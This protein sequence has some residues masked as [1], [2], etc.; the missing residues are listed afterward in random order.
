MKPFLTVALGLFF[1]AQVFAG[2]GNPSA[3]HFSATFTA[4]LKESKE[5]FEPMRARVCA[6]QVLQ[7][8]SKNE[9][10]R[11]IAVFAE[12]TNTGDLS[13]N[14]SDAGAVLTKE[15]KHLKDFFY[16]RIQVAENV[17]APMP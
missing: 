9:N 3:V 4:S 2:P 10:D 8:S 1:A 11:L 14:F 12:A 13:R 6:C 17:T 15:K 7:V 16:S 5:L